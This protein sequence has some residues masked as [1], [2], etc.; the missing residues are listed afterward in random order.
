MN[1]DK[2]KI[3]QIQLPDLADDDPHPRLLVHI[4]AW[5]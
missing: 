1:W 5:F 3:A 2:E 4:Y